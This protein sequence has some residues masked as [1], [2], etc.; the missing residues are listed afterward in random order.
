[1]ISVSGTLPDLRLCRG[2]DR[3]ECRCLVEAS[4]DRINRALQ[5][6]SQRDLLGGC[7][8]F[9]PKKK[10]YDVLTRK[11]V[12]KHLSL[13]F[14]RDND[15]GNQLA[16]RIAPEDLEICACHK[17]ECTGRRILFASLLQ[18]GREDYL[19]IVCRSG[20]EICDS[21]L[22]VRKDSTLSGIHP[23]GSPALIDGEYE[24][25]ESKQG[26]LRYHYLNRL[27]TAEEPVAQLYD[28]ACLP[29]SNLEHYDDPKKKQSS[30]SHTVRRITFLGD[31]HKLDSGSNHFILKTFRD[32]LDTE[33]ARSDFEAEW[34]ANRQAPRHDRIVS[35]L[36]AFEFRNGYHLIFPLAPERD[37]RSVWEKK[38]SANVPGYSTRWLLNEC[39][40][41]AEAVAAIHEPQSLLVHLDIKSAN[42]LCF[43]SRTEGQVSLKLKLSDFG[44]SRTLDELQKHGV[45]E[46]TVTYSPPELEFGDDILLKYDVWSLGCLYLE[47]ITWAFYGVQGVS[48]FSKR[49][50]DELDDK[51]TSHVKGI[52][53]ADRFFKRLSHARK[54]HDIRSIR[55]HGPYQ[56]TDPLSEKTTRSLRNFGSVSRENQ[57]HNQLKKCV[58][59]HI[60]DLDS[61]S[62]NIPE[63]QG[64]LRIIKDRMLVIDVEKRASSA[65][66]RADL[67]NLIGSDS[68]SISN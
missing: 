53:K 1:M 51:R 2:C 66:I 34:R 33:D 24:L 30:S 57:I 56:S 42:I 20:S 11:T 49:R 13:F 9:I 46:S 45:G 62:Q 55:F 23:N 37:L 41:I 15:L 32:P 7:R 44:I 5:S 43:E 6:S 12:A 25:L 29:L 61:K 68:A 47:F 26:Q 27:Y 10:L 35:L 63:F 64:L 28:G 52:N 19:R 31:H 59:D 36:C 48:D 39:V 50:L 8:R 4:R 58:R 3:I 17:V 65:D 16:A 14:T 22:P 18:I 38:E 67:Q 60:S 40:G 54:W 21:S